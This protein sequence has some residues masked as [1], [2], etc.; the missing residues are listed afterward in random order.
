MN[1]K[2][3][4]SPTRLLATR[5]LARA[6]LATMGCVWALLCT[7]PV[8]AI[9]PEAPVD[10]LDV[11]VP[12]GFMLMVLEPKQLASLQVT[13]IVHREGE[14]LQRETVEWKRLRMLNYT[15]PLTR[16]DDF[17]YRDPREQQKPESDRVF[18]HPAVPSI[19]TAKLRPHLRL[20][21]PASRTV[22]EDAPPVRVGVLIPLESSLKRG[23]RDGVYAEKFIARAQLAGEPAKGKPLTMVRWSHFEMRDGQASYISQAE[24]S[25]MLDPATDGVDGSGEKIQLN[26]GRDVKA[27]VPISRT[28]KHYAVPLGRLGGVAPE[29]DNSSKLKAA[30]PRETDER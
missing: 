17:Q 30:S 8:A 7:S 26:L 10:F 19:D 29:R 21:S 2:V 12:K 20:A 1:P 23:L 6:V 13:R 4:P 24:Y 5:R 9:G 15:A 22:I 3:S 11:Y 25:R 27:N 16:E 14:P 18:D 28:K